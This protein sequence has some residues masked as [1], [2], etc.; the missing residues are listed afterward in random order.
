[1][2]KALFSFIIILAGI[3]AWQHSKIGK[4]NENVRIQTGNVEALL[5]DIQEYKIDSAN[6]AYV[7]RGLQLTKNEY[8]DLREKDLKTI[9]GLQLKIKNIEAVAKSELE[10]SQKIVSALQD[11][12]IK[13]DSMFV[14]AK[15]VEYKDE[16]S[17]FTG[18]ITNDSIA[19]DFY[20]VV[21]LNQV[22]YTTYKWKFLW[23]KGPIKDVRQVI[24]TNNK[25]AKL[26]Y[27]EYIKIR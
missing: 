26:K 22:F 6:T 9:Q 27:A 3:V 19:A 23:F 24:T 5:S 25:H 13:K 16:S 10:I 21:E 12:I 7:V 11:T 20:T 8:E 18:I 17:S 2:K 15:K 4:L 14:S 1:M